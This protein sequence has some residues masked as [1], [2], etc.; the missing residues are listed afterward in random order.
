MS[1]RPTPAASPTPQAD[2]EYRNLFRVANVRAE[3]DERGGG[4]DTK[5]AGGTVPNHHHHCSRHH[6]HQYL[7]L[8]HVWITPAERDTATWTEGQERG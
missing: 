1:Q 8:G 2:Q 6:R 3:A 5:G 4:K 7:C